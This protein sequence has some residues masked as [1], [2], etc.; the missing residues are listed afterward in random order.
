MSSQFQL[1]MRS[2]P[3]PGKVFL[4]TAVDMLLGR[5]DINEIVINDPEISRKHAR[6]Y[7]QGN[8]Y[9]VEDLGSTNGTFINGKRL[10]GPVTLQ[11]GATLR[12]GDNVVLAFEIIG[13]EEDA[14]KVAASNFEAAVPATPPQQAAPKPMYSGQVAESPPKQAAPAAPKK[15]PNWL[16]II[17]I[18]AILII[19]V[20]AIAIGAWLY[21]APA[22]TWCQISFDLIPGCPIT[23]P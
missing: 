20:V 23:A 10:S 9:V 8:S 11:P 12:F 4:L 22:D 7:I 14:T 21:N 13:V 3:T 2:G 16:M 19:C 15:G 1:V 18:L 17:G 5:D 6:L